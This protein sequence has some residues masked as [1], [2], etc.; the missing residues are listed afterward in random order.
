MEP[1][2]I[3]KYLTYTRKYQKGGIQRSDKINDSGVALVDMQSNDLWSIA[4]LLL[5]THDSRFAYCYSYIF[6]KDETSLIRF[7]KDIFVKLFKKVLRKYKSDQNFCYVLTRLCGFSRF[8]KQNEYSNNSPNQIYQPL[9]YNQRDIKFFIWLLTYGKYPQTKIDKYEDGE[10]LIEIDEYRTMASNDSLYDSNSEMDHLESEVTQYKTGKQILATLDKQN[11]IIEQEMEK[12]A[13]H[14][15]PEY[16]YYEPTLYE[17][18]SYS[19]FEQKS[20]V[21]KQIKSK[22]ILPNKQPIQKFEKI[23]IYTYENTTKS[24]PNNT[25]IIYNFNNFDHSNRNSSELGSKFLIDKHTKTKNMSKIQG[26]KVKDRLSTIPY[27]LPIFEIPSDH[28]TKPCRP[29][30][31]PPSMS[32]GKYKQKITQTYK[33][34]PKEKFKN[35]EFLEPNIHE[36][37]ESENKIL[38]SLKRISKRKIQITNIDEIGDDNTLLNRHKG[39]PDYHQNE[40]NICK[41]R[42]CTKAGSRIKPKYVRPP[43]AQ[44]DTKK[45]VEEMKKDRLESRIKRVSRVK[46]QEPK[47]EDPYNRFNKPNKRNNDYYTGLNNIDSISKHETSHY[48]TSKYKK[49]RLEMNFRKN[50]EKGW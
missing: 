5:L 30:P 35:E 37:L 8:D 7:D 34:K 11:K 33:S 21:Q 26:S 39:E 36:L 50:D 15:L 3:K 12:H 41:C 25:D 49:I 4:F 17:E 13:Q 18:P 32:R 31:K 40:T 28:P 1:N 24:V 9:V 16:R 38:K 29:I 43:L 10:H 23:P 14:P 2:L 48:K 27:T 20:Y 45:S 22:K 19:F 44:F 6:D 47:Y 46:Y 42:L